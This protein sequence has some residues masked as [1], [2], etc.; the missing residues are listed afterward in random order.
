MKN[1]VNWPKV[2]GLEQ[3]FHDMEIEDDQVFL[4]MQKAEEGADRTDDSL[5]AANEGKNK[6]HRT[7]MKCQN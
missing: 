6:S 7:F 3:I 1:L 5:D 2:V 4:D